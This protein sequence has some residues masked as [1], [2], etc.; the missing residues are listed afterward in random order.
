MSKLPELDR[1]SVGVSFVDILFALAVGQ[2]LMPIA[3]WAQAQDPQKSSL[4]LVNWLH[5]GVAFTI[6]IASWIGYH[7]SA[8]RAGFQ[9]RFFNVEF[10]KLLLD[11]AM[12]AVYFVLAAF[13]ARLPAQIR[14]ETSLVLAAFVLYAFW[15]LAAVYQKGNKDYKDVWTDA[16]SDSARTD[17]NKAWSPTDWG[18]V[19]ATF[20]CLVVSGAVCLYTWTV[21]SQHVSRTFSIVIDCGLLVL[22]LFYRKLKQWLSAKGFSPKTWAVVYQHSDAGWTVHVPALPD[23]PAADGATRHEAKDKVAKAVATYL[24]SLATD[25]KAIP[26]PDAFDVGSVVPDPKP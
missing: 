19:W 25:R 7:E 15:D 9:P 22:L 3:V 11:I 8:N 21:A 14:P 24:S 4:P 6:T 23:M 26:D 10:V 17:V 2:I 20:V 18:R 16:F 5:L 12:V 1:A 13:A